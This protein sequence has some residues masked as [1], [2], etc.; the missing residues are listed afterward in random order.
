[1]ASAAN[2]QEA[3][4]DIAA[5]VDR[6]VP[7]DRFSIA[8]VD[9]QGGYADLYVDDRRVKEWRKGE[10]FRLPADVPI[11]AI[12]EK[13]PPGTRRSVHPGLTT[14]FPARFPSMLRVPIELNGSI[15][16]ALTLRSEKAQAYGPAQLEIARR[17][18]ARLAPAVEASRR[19]DR[20]TRALEKLS[21]EV[22]A[23]SAALK[24][25]AE[26]LTG[27]LSSMVVAVAE[28]REVFEQ[29][30]APPHADRLV[31]LI[32]GGAERLRST[33]AASLEYLNYSAGRRPGTS[34]R[35]RLATIARLVLE[36]Y[37][38]EIQSSGRSL[39]VSIDDELPEISVSNAEIARVVRVLLAN[40]LTYSPPKDSITLTIS[41]EPAYH[42]LEI[43][44]TRA[45]GVRIDTGRIFEPFYRGRQAAEV[46]HMGSGLG[47]AIA[48]VIAR[49]HGGDLHA[50]LDGARV[51]LVLTLPASFRTFIP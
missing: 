24:M 7:F 48:R 16:G 15:I 38:M 50:E 37:E 32:E 17:L 19:S 12:S 30:D 39:S 1:M 34:N 9:E 4:S 41:G 28:L 3:Y 31:A 45:P 8:V 2:L 33:M 36:Q 22:E 10:T 42:R 51:A 14:S 6:L 47:L 46:R 21:K 49:N 20:Q 18:A 29:T 35:S 27:P 5:Q 25:I 13:R 43:A 44:N 40:A 26:N 11:E 23:Q